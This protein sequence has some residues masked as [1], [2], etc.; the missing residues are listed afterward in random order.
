MKPKT[1]IL[2][3][4]LLSLLLV[5]CQKA[6]TP[7][8]GPPTQTLLRIAYPTALAPLLPAIETCYQALPAIAVIADEI[9]GYPSISEM[10]SAG[11]Q[12]AFSLGDPASETASEAGYQAPLGVESLDVIVN[13]KNPVRELSAEQL[14]GVY[15]G[16]IRDWQALGGSSGEIQ[17]WSFLSIDPARH[18][19]YRLVLP[20]QSARSDT[21]VA[22]DPAAMMRAIAADP[23]AIG[24]LPHAWVVQQPNENIK[25]VA[26]PKN[27][28]AELSVPVLAVA[29]AE[30]RG[31][32]RDFLACLQTGAGHQTLRGTYLPWQASTP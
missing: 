11:T 29:P 1:V 32:D 18:I 28:A 24:Y 27:L 9:P 21:W 23:T 19:F 26:L 14:A 7:A 30:P 2:R 8:P 5:S 25:E 3:A 31:F 20:G 13:T 17:V 10:K 16:K 22:P 4:L 6:T 12:L 15:R